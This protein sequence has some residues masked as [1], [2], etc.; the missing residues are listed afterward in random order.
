MSPTNPDDLRPTQFP[1][2]LSALAPLRLTETTQDQSVAH[3]PKTT[4]DRPNLLCV[5]APLRLCV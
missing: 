4:P 5:L 2:R 1:L 3:Q